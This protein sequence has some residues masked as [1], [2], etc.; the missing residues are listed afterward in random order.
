MDLIDLEMLLQ[1]KL[2]RKIFIP[3]R[4]LHMEIYVRTQCIRP[5]ETYYNPY[6]IINSRTMWAIF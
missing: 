6:D 2:E 1:R 5:E 4:K 3:L